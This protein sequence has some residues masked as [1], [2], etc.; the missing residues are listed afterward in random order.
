MVMDDRQASGVSFGEEHFGASILGDVRRTRRLVQLAND[1][2]KHP[3]GT[4][5]DKLSDPASLKAMYRL[6]ANEAVTHESVLAVSRERTLRLASEAEGTVLH[7]HDGTELDYSTLHSLTG[8]GQIGNGSRRGYLAH[9]TLTVVAQTRDVIGLAYQKLTKRPKRPK[10]ETRKQRRDRPDRESRM[11]KTASMAIPAA[12]PGR[13]WVEVADRGADLLEFIDYQESAGKSYLVRSKHNRC[14]QWENGE[15]MKLHDYARS[16][17]PVGMKSVEVPATHKHPARTATVGIAWGEVTLL[18]PI[19]PRGEVRGVPLKA[20]VICV[21]EIAPPAGVEA[22]EWILLTNVSVVDL[23]DALERISWYECRWIIEE[24]HKALKTGVGVEELQFTKEERLQPVIALLS[25]VALF[26][27]NLRNASRRPDA[28]ERPASELLPLVFVT[29][30]ALWRYKKVC[31]E[32]TVHEFY[33]ALAR[34]GG[35]QNRKH[36]HRPGWLV[37]WRG[38]TK[39]QAMVDIALALDRQK[40]G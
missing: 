26:L 9:N 2:V 17:P 31:A 11:W 27:L 34:L 30:L 3:G 22:V 33:Y 37:L 28:Q 15:K 16:L 39:L 35:H 14:I 12:P 20:W 4:L 36:D 1:M 38:W 21:R 40:C 7:I 8:L 13:V 18:V 6:A 10:K 5:P 23:E 24:Y 19:Q 25:V 29:T 32:M